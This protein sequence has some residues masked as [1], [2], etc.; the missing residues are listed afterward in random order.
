MIRAPTK[1]DLYTCLDFSAQ[2]GLFMFATQGD[3]R[4][5]L[6]EQSFAYQYSTTLHWALCQLGARLRRAKA[7]LNGQDERM[8]SMGL[9]QYKYVYCIY[10]II[11]IHCISRYEY[12]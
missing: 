8:R 10:I 4:S 12:I 3:R 9:H 2:I 7:S 1:Q 5:G 11:Y 6:A